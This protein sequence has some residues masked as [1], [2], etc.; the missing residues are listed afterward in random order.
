M[1]L[2]RIQDLDMDRKNVLLRLDLNVPM[3]G[4]EISD[5]TRISAALPTIK[6]VAERAK[7]FAICSHLGR[8]EG[9]VNDKFSLE[10]IGARLADVLD[11]EVVFFTDYAT[12]PIKPVLEQM[13]VNQFMLLENLRFHSGE[14]TNDIEFSRELA[15]GFDCYVD[16][17]FGTVHRSHASVVGVT[18]SFE[19]NHRAA[20]FLIQKET[21]VLT[22][23]LKDPKA[24]VTVVMGGAKV[25]DKISVILKLLDVCNNLLIGGAMAYTFLKF[26]G[27][28][29]GSSRVEPDS[30]D[31]VERI[32]H[33]AEK[34]NVK[35]ML[36]VDHVAASEFSEESPA[37]N[38][39][40]KDIPQGLMGLDIGSQTTENFSR[41]I[42]ASGTVFW[43]GPMGVFE[44]QNFSHGSCGIAKAMAES[45]A[46][47]IIGGGD[48]VAAVNRVGLADKMSHIST[49]GGAAL[50]F[51]E[52]KVLPGLRVLAY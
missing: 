44:W 6:Y 32:Y 36:P 18:Q 41:V 25:S 29:V 50:E 39:E 46:D 42:G 37:I 47:T 9:E 22:S 52:G 19:P 1:K 35:I 13:S 7:R 49:G 11:K 43:N 26:K 24:P 12:T 5:E 20:G 14:K 40:G 48:S 30:F 21:D 28:L 38:V 4:K 33:Q 23:L 31:L 2:R 16:D 51:L 10:P 34:R 17:A 15:A 45:S 27:A 8:P 3:H